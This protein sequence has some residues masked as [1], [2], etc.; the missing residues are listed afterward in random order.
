MAR[1]KNVKR[2][3]PRYFLNETTYRGLNEEEQYASE[4]AAIPVEKLD[5]NLWSRLG[6]DDRVYK[7]PGQ[8]DYY[9]LTIRMD[10]QGEK[11]SKV[12][13]GTTSSPSSV[14]AVAT[15]QGVRGGGEPSTQPELDGR[16]ALTDPGRF[17]VGVLIGTHI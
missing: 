3:D 5:S 4:T 2:I 7:V 12:L 9:Q 15:L 14:I 16:R 1:R 11:T 13:Y 6:S 10:P 8:E 17:E